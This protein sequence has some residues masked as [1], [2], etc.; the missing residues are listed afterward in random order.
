[1]NTDSNQLLAGMSMPL[2]DPELLS[3]I[4]ATAG[5]ISLVVSA[6][7]HVM[8]VLANP[9]HASFGRLSHWV[10]RR[11]A[12]I[13]TSESLV[14]FQR[15]LEELQA[16]GTR[17]VAV[18][19]NHVDEVIS[20]FPIRY[21]MH[22]IGADKAILMLG[23][24]LRPIA[25]MQQQ[26][27][28]AQIVLERDYET[29][30]EMDTRY[31]V[32]MDA[33]RDAVVLVAMN[34]GRIADLNAAAAV[35][36]GGSRQE[37]VGA[38]IAQEFEG[39]RR[40]EFLESLTN[41][42]SASSVSPVELVARRSQRKLRVI[43][44]LFRAA[45]ERLMLCRIET[46]EHGARA[47]NETSENLERLFHEG[48]DAI[49]LLDDDGIITAANEAFLKLTDSS[50]VANVRGRSMADFLAR[51]SVDLRVLLDNTKRARQLRLYATKVLN[52]FNGQVPVEISATHLNDRPKPGYGL[53]IRDASRAEILRRTDM[54][55]GPDGMR[56]VIELVGSSTLK[57]IVAETTEVVE[58]MCIQTAVDL[59]RNNRVAAAEMLGL[60]RQSLY[61]KLRKFGLLAKDD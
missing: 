16:P 56:S 59:T 27:V 23:R 25:E 48:V 20:E 21:T 33:T 40:S 6:D 8:S 46:T 37:L 11:A 49:V 24:D 17:T 19:L 53:V 9:H 29:Q 45:G 7:G 22:C 15:R 60:S 35:M 1:V 44:K 30:R 39:R 4:V 51:G 58:K 32:L 36:L 43:P 5:D 42:A 38:A 10:G 14:K 3:D 54:A 26:L 12:D 2:I 47:Q 61:V 18:E 55:T 28:M 50:H 52:E 41:I 13:M 31:R 57:D 34:N